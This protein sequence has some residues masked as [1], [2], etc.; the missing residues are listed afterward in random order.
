MILPLLGEYE[1]SCKVV[2]I[3][4]VSF[5]SYSSLRPKSLVVWFCYVVLH[6]SVS[7]LSPYDL[8]I[9]DM[10]SGMLLVASYLHP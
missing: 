4:V 9:V 2:G 3:L 5:N 8:N 10:M 6:I 7:C 1:L